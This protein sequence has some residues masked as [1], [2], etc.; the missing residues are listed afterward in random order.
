MKLIKGILSAGVFFIAAFGST[1]VQAAP[2]TIS[3]T[4]HQLQP[5]S[6]NQGWWSSTVTNNNPTNDNYFTGKGDTSRSFFSFDLSGLS[7]VVTSATF[8][9]RRYDQTQALTLG[10]FD[11]VTP[12]ATLITTRTNVFNPTIFQDLGSGHSY[13][14]FDVGMGYSTDILSFALNAAALADI[15]AAIGARYFSIGAAVQGPGTIFSGSLD[16]PGNSLS[17]SVQQLVLNV[18]PIAAVPEPASLALAGLGLAG[19][20]CTR[21]RK[22]LK[23][24]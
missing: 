5:G 16:E 13:G 20:G 17:N 21:R 9:V 7:G 10:L 3:T 24:A 1:V 18:E 6:D 22:A 15:N 11:V 14:S 2:V 12:A 8:Q 4:F 23:A 19:L